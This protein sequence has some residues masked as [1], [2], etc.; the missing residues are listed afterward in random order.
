MF[1]DPQFWVAIAFFAFIAAVFS[2]EVSKSSSFKAPIIP[3]LPASTLPILS[4]CAR[5]VSRTPQALALITEV[6][7]PDWA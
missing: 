5:A 2:L 3:F 7:P 1:S 4:P 6:T